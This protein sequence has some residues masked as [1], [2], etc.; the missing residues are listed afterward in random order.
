M[1]KL[2]EL[3]KFEQMIDPHEWSKM[4]R[5]R[6]FEIEEPIGMDVIGA[7]KGMMT[8]KFGPKPKLDE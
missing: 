8:V 3:E 4:K 6:L 2:G 1:E 7:M 5:P